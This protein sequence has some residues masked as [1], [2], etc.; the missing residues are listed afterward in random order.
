MS[1]GCSVMIVLAAASKSSA[2]SAPE[3]LVDAGARYRTVDLSLPD[4]SDLLAEVLSEWQPRAIVYC[5]V[6]YGGRTDPS[7]ADAERL[8]RVNALVPYLGLKRFLNDA[9]HACSVVFVNSDSIYSANDHSGLYAASKASL[10]VFA[11][12]LA[13]ACRST[14][15]SVSTLLLGPLA[16]EKKLGELASLAERANIDVDEMTHRFLRRSNPSLVIDEL[17]DFGSCFESVR[18]MVDLGAAA[19]G[20]LCKL[21]GGSSGSLV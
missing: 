6:E 14:S 10:R 19:N 18:Y 3:E 15:A 12:A 17:I 5:A 2:Q 9:T 20:M 4:S 21:D 16:D 8:F 11:T 13:A 1:P 7:L